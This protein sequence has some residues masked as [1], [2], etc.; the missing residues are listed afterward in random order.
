MTAREA[1][2]AL[3]RFGG[4]DAAGSSAAFFKAGPG[5]YAEHDRFLG[6]SAGELRAV[7]KAFR[8]L[9]AKELEKLL[10]SAYNEERCLALVILTL[11]YPRDPDKVYKLYLKNLRAVNNWNLVDASAPYILGPHLL[12]HS[13]AVLEK[14]ARSPRL[15]DRRVAVVS[16]WALIRA[17]EFGPTLRLCK[18]LLDDREDLMHKAC[19]WMLREVGKRDE[20]ALEGFLAKHHSRMPRTMLRYAIERFPPRR[21]KAWLL[22]E[23]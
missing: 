22:G 20:A 8:E 4:K 21:R 10:R 6:V 13:R 1:S 7:A 15:W 3:R 17:G 11:Q 9:A 2:E 12:T 18:L 14:L 19:G 5:G 23:V 16:T